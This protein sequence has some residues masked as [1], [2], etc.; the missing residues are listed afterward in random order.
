M[1]GIVLVLLNFEKPTIQNT[2]Y[3]T[4]GDIKT[5]SFKADFHFISTFLVLSEIYLFDVLY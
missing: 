5:G 4:C 3:L 2:K 1:L